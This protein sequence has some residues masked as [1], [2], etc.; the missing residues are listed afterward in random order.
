ML[1]RGHRESLLRWRDDGGKTNGTFG[2]LLQELPEALIDH[3]RGKYRGYD[4]LRASLK[5]RMGMY[6]RELEPT[7]RAV[8]ALRE[9]PA[10]KLKKRLSEVLRPV[11]HPSVEM[12][13]GA[14]PSMIQAAEALVSAERA[15]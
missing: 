2:R 3:P 9:T 6:L 5:R 15:P 11:W 8:A 12:P 10:R 14:F 4:D 7:L 1:L 13:R